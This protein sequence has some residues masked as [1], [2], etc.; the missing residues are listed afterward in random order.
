MTCCQKKR[1]AK[2][3]NLIQRRVFESDVYTTIKKI[4]GT[5]ICL[6]QDRILIKTH[7]RI[8]SIY[9]KAI[10]FNP[11]N[12]KFIQNVVL[13]HTSYAEEIKKRRISHTSPI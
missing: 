11:P 4:K 3:R 12:K 13:M 10:K 8:H 6:L 1:K 2:T 9:N 7:N 5:D